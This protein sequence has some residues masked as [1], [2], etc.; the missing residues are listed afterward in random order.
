MEIGNSNIFYLSEQEA[1]KAE[2]KVL[3]KITIIGV[4]QS[5]K[6][7]LVDKL[8]DKNNEM[9]SNV[10]VPTIMI[11]Y[12]FLTGKYHD[13]LYF[14]LVF[15]DFSGK[16]NLLPLSIDY[17]SKSHV[18]MFLFKSDLDFEKQLINLKSILKLIEGDLLANFNFYL[19]ILVFN[20]SQQKA[21]PTTSS[22]EKYGK[23][24]LEVQEIFNNFSNYIIVEGNAFKEINLVDVIKAN[25]ADY[26]INKYNDLAKIHETNTEFTLFKDNLDNEVNY[27]I[28]KGLGKLKK[29]DNACCCNLY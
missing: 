26:C 3:F 24:K 6:S 8:I 18:I 9:H 16:E 2:P 20:L 21:K 29:E 23:F 10:Y 1:L 14:K 4:P 11:N 7:Y 13:D 19:K 12:R 22:T 25:I 15:Y 17:A 27:T 28:P 5:G